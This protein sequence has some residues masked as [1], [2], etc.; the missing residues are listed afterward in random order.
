MAFLALGLATAIPAQEARN[1]DIEGTIQS[2]IEAFLADDF[3][4][5]FGFASPNIQGLFGSSERFGQMVRQG[6]P[7]VW[8]PGDVQY[9]ELRSIDGRLWQKVMIVDRAGLP[10]LLDYQMIET[11][12]GWRINAVQLLRAPTVGA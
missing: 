9:L 4:R 6:Y 12:E 10:H 5:A 7:M 1:S 8:R 11:P 2:Q 3:E